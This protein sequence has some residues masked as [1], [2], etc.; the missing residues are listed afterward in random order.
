[1]RGERWGGVVGGCRGMREWL[2]A[3][4]TVYVS[5]PRRA[6]PLSVGVLCAYI[7]PGLHAWSVHT[8][9]HTHLHTHRQR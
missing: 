4:E 6:R 9:T 8:H 1:M 2:V 7:H 3:C 5:R